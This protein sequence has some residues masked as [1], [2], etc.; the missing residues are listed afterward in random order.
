VVSKPPSWEVPRLEIKVFVSD[1]VLSVVKSRIW[2]VE[3]ATTCSA[4]INCNSAVVREM[5][6][7]EFN[8]ATWDVD[9]CEK[10]VGII[11]GGS[12]VAI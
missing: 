9:S 7:S 10:S 12:G 6:S 5:I 11:S 3:S 4:L 8:A 1:V 2:P